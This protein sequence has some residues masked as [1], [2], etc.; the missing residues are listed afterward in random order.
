[1]RSSSST[2]PI[3]SGTGHCEQSYGRYLSSEVK[4]LATCPSPPV[5]PDRSYEGLGSLGVGAMGEVYC[6]RDIRL[7]REVASKVLPGLCG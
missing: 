5:G 1:M 7:D 4:L 3:D 6:A 2:T